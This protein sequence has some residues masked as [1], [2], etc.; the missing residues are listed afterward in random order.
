M[1]IRL[2]YVNLFLAAAYFLLFLQGSSGLVIF[3]LLMV[4]VFALLNAV[5]GV[6]SGLLYRIA[7][8]FSGLQSLLFAVFL[9]YSAWYVAADSAVHG[10]YSGDSILLIGFNLGFGLCILLHLA[11]FIKR[12]LNN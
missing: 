7:L 5:A 3:G 8:Y 6:G 1:L 11:F 12:S 4:L 10:Y 2:S 9:L